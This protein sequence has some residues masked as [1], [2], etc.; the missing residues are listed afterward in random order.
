[1][2]KFK[3]ESICSSTSI[4]NKVKEQ[5]NEEIVL[6]PYKWAQF[7]FEHLKKE[8]RNEER[9]IRKEMSNRKLFQQRM[10]K[11]IKKCGIHIIALHLFQLKLFYKMKNEIKISYEYVNELKCGIKRIQKISTFERTMDKSSSKDAFI[12]HKMDKMKV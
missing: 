2:G 11:N 3:K 12:C 1:M 9:K 4:K 7:N 8:E 6:L 5:K 10:A